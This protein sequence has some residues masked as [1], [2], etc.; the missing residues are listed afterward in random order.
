MFF[1]AGRGPFLGIIFEFYY[2][3][4][5]LIQKDLSEKKSLY[6]SSQENACLLI[7]TGGMGGENIFPCFPF[8]RGVFLVDLFFFSLLICI[9]FVQKHYG[10]NFSGIRFTREGDNGGVIFTFLM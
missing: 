10:H 9:V 8:P 1:G 2:V 4:P 6:R 7:N 3:R 5:A